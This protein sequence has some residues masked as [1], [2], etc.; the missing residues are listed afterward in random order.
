MEESVSV[1]CE[2]QARRGELSSCAAVSDSDSAVAVIG[3]W[4]PKW[5]VKQ[6]V[7]H[8]AVVTVVISHSVINAHN[9]RCLHTCVCVWTPVQGFDCLLQ[10]NSELQ[11]DNRELWV[12]SHHAS[13]GTAGVQEP[14]HIS[15][16]SDLGRKLPSLNSDVR[17]RERGSQKKGAR[18]RQWDSRRQAGWKTDASYEKNQMKENR[19]IGTARLY[20]KCQNQDAVLIKV[21]WSSHYLWSSKDKSM[22]QFHFD[23]KT[24]DRFLPVF[25]SL[26][27]LFSLSVFLPLSLAS[28]RDC[29]GLN[30]NIKTR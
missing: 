29:I 20:S 27:S 24:Q 7:A 2:Q 3:S 17:G 30:M 9:Q 22:R 5:P 14:R 25:F 10:P 1:V 12:I 28:G 4:W 16:H 26:F 18:D 21:K 11:S 8:T 13:S 19:E 23:E 15:S 6:G